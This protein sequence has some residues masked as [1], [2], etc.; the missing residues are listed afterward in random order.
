MRKYFTIDFQWCIFFSGGGAKFELLVGLGKK[1]YFKKKRK[2]TKKEVEKLVIRGNFHCSLG[3][4]IILEKRCGIKN[5]FFSDNIYPCP[6]FIKACYL[7]KNE[8]LS[9]LVLVELCLCRVFLK[10]INI[11][12]Y[13]HFKHLHNTYIHYTYIPFRI[14]FTQL[15]H[16]SLLLSLCVIL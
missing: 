15:I 16:Y 7:F 10:K 6:F 5:I 2:Y 8:F 13:M 4:N 1:W 14:I 12:Q 11:I 9:C 3:E